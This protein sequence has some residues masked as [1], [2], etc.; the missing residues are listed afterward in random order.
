VPP[1]R[2]RDVLRVQ[3]AVLREHVLRDDV[4]HD[5]SLEEGSAFAS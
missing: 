2:V 3:R 4:R 5:A 1:E